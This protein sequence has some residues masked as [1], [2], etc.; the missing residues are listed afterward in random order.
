MP[1]E[2]VPDLEAPKPPRIM[3][4]LRAG[5]SHWLTHVVALV[6]TAIGF[7]HAADRFAL[8]G[9]PGTSFAFGMF[10]LFI[11][12]GSFV[13]AVSHFVGRIA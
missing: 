10:G 5:V 1:G 12:M 7:A 6:A 4:A 2:V 11:G 13:R 8:A 3:P 9:L